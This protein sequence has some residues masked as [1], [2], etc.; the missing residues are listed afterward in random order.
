MWSLFRVIIWS[1]YLV[2]GEIWTSTVCFKEG[3]SFKL[4]GCGQRGWGVKKFALL[5]GRHK[6]MTPYYFNAILSILGACKNYGHR[7]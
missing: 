7:V 3:G 2:L 1:F 4:D 6:W 5:C